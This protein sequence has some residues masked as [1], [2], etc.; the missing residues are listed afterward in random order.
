MA[1]RALFWSTLALGLAL[2]AWALGAESFWHDEAWT[3]GIT[4]GSPGDLLHRVIRD[5]AHPPLYFLLAQA[6]SLVG[7]SEAWMRLLSVLLGLAALPLVARVGRRLGGEAV[8][9]A[10]MLLAALSPL[11]VAYSREARSYALL[12]LLC[13]LSLDLL[14]R[15]A[16][17]RRTWLA[18]AAVN[19][20]ILLTHY[21]GVFFLAPQAI[22][23]LVA[24]PASRKPFLLATAG[25]A[26]LF[27]PWLPVFLG[28]ASRVARGFWITFPTP[29]ELSWSL[30]ELVSSPRAGPFLSLPFFALAL[31]AGRR[32]RAFLA[33]LAGPILLE[34]AA[35]LA[36]PVFYT[37]TLI[38]VTAPLWVLSA[39]SLASLPAKTRLAATL[40]A[41][42][43]LV[44]GLL[45]LHGA[46]RKEDWRNAA[47]LL[48]R[49]PGEN[50]RVLVSPGHL[51]MGLDY[52]RAPG[53]LLLVEDG[54]ML[55]PASPAE[56]VR[57]ELDR[58]DGV[59]VVWRY[60]KDGAALLGGKFEKR[61]GW[62]GRSIGIDYYLRRRDP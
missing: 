34:L 57:A 30:A 11:H 62:R 27:L 45:F 16:P 28:H 35:S 2:R 24:R 49:A 21:M 5:D 3:W 36:R 58:A 60:G 15:D 55:R 54:D 31:A 8:G 9:R 39:A 52:Y 51:A 20:G 29:V 56:T 40:T 38:Y 48:R 32:H 10:A 44:P 47:D 12:F 13:V 6:W 59:W 19:A 61:S 41:A 53:R 4:R 23:F 43:L 14:F 46:E 25:A 1:A 50:E 37:P 22:A 17:T 7:T 26:A 42:G 18:F 33:L